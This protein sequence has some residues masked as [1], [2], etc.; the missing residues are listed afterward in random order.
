MIDL[1]YAPAPPPTTLR[2]TSVLL[3]L[4]FRTAQRLQCRSAARHASFP[5]RWCRGIER[6]ELMLPLK[7]RMFPQVE[8]KAGV[9]VRC[10]VVSR[11]PSLYDSRVRI[12]GN[13][14][15]EIIRPAANT[16][17]QIGDPRTHLIT[18]KRPLLFS[19]I[20]TLFLKNIK[21]PK[22]NVRRLG[23]FIRSTSDAYTTYV[24]DSEG[25]SSE[26]EQQSKPAPTAHTQQV[27]KPQPG[28]KKWEGEDE[29]GDDGPV[30][31]PSSYI[32]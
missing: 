32:F 27:K 24:S 14:E 6:N 18:K 3:R 17:W 4:R 21:N 11:E 19:L 29:D 30:V 31:C 2:P 8:V 9:N 5:L 16:Y 13:H 25:S 23:Y 10:V 15:T 1:P 28:G 20:H 26:E 22:K 7:T 12:P